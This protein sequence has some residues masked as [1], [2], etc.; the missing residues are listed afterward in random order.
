MTTINFPATMERIIRSAGNLRV[1]ADAGVELALA[2]DE[3]GKSISRDAIMFA[4]HDGRCTV[5]AC[6]IKLAVKMKKLL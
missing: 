3:I 1:G 4:E 5:K 2:L 6:D